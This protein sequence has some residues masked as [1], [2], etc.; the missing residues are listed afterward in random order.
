ML[1]VPTGEFS[2][3]IST[4]P[5]PSKPPPDAK[6]IAPPVVVDDRPE[7]TTTSA[8]CCAPLPACTPIESPLAVD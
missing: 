8:P 4:V 2:V 1:P 7:D 5:V 3:F 6:W